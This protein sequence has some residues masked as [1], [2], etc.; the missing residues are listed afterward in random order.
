MKVVYQGDETETSQATVGG[1]LAERHVPVA[2]SIVEY[3]GE[4]YPPGADL[5][6][7]ALRDGAPL[8]VFRLTAGG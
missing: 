6:S 7:V 3:A 1:F 4:V 8:E 2:S 5:A